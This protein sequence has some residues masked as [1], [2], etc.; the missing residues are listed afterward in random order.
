MGFISGFTH[1]YLR[2]LNIYTIPVLLSLT[3]DADTLHFLGLPAVVSLMCDGPLLS[4]LFKVYFCV[5]ISNSRDDP[6]RR[7]VP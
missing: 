7:S 1:I 4:W 2:S 5:V 3:Y 6:I